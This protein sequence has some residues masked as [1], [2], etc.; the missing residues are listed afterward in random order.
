VALGKELFAEC[1][2]KNSTM[3][4]ALDKESN[5]GSDYMK[6]TFVLRSIKFFWVSLFTNEGY[7]EQIFVVH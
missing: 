2:K 6:R 7:E 4:L 1:P 3:N 5:F